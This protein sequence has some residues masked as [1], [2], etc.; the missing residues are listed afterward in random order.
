[1]GIMSSGSSGT[2]VPPPLPPDLTLWATIPVNVGETDIAGLSVALHSGARISGS[3]V[4]EGTK[5]QPTGDQLQRASVQ[6]NPIAGTAPVQILTA[7]KRV[8]ANGQFASVG[9]PPGKYTVSAA[10]PPIQAG[11]VAWRFK[12]ATFRGRDVSDEGLTVAG[13]DVSGLVITFTDRS[14]EVRGTVADAKGQPDPNAS[15]VVL[16]ADSQAW[17]QGTINARRIRSTRAT[18]TGA[19]GFTD[20]PPGAYFIAA[21]SEESLENWQD[22]KTLE[23]IARVATHFTLGDGEKTTQS[24]ITRTL[25]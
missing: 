4:F 16:P 20:L 18:S 10:L 5:E 17:K 7:A 1:M 23:A 8:E 3:L 15:V 6:I 11:G 22:P 2:S 12:S 14:T 24:L 25:R 19:F 21:I 13:E 9:Y